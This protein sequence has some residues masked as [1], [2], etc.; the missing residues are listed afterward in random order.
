MNPLTLLPEYKDT[1]I[2]LIELAA[3]QL[4]LGPISESRANR[5]DWGNY[6]TGNAFDTLV[7]LKLAEKLG[8][9][10]YISTPLLMQNHAAI[11]RIS[12][13]AMAAKAGKILPTK[14][15]KV[16]TT[17]LTPKG[18]NATLQAFLEAGENA[19]ALAYAELQ[20]KPLMFGVSTNS[21]K[22]LPY[23][24]CELLDL[25]GMECFVGQDKKG[26]WNVLVCA[27]GIS[28]CT[29][30]VN[31]DQIINTKAGAILWAKASLE[32]L[33]KKGIDIKTV[34]TRFPRVTQQSLRDKF[35]QEGINHDD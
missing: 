10:T 27:I 8:T 3:R 29:P 28:T 21:R 13:D 17:A 35:N 19:N 24:N 6:T 12:I 22:T 14:V 16:K 20:G 15:K 25:D 18:S 23:F 32:Y 26:T 4:V 34:I 33:A 9:G 31:K 11:K 30:E 1:D 5:K 7:S 2:N